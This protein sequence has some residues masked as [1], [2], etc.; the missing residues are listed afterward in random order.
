VSLNIT[1]KKGPPPPTFMGHY[2]GFISRLMA[3]FIDIMVVSA[4]IGLMLVGLNLILTFFNI[5]LEALAVGNTDFGNAVLGIFK[6]LTGFTFTFLVN[7]VYN[8]FFWMAAGK[9]IGKAVMGLQVIGPK[10]SRVTFWQAIKRYY[11][12][13]ISAIPFFLGYFW[14][15]VSD[16]RLAWHDIIAGTSVIYDHEAQYSEQLLGRIARIVP[17]LENKLDKKSLTAGSQSTD[18]LQTM[19]DEAKE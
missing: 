18:I 5:D 3:F 11:G 8:V 15:L 10:G 2:A 19:P 6:F 1:R 4:A 17:H 13:W 16:R 7:L 12:Y 14:V 9:T